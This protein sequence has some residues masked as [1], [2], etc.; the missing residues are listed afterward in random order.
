MLKNYFIVAYRNLIHNKLYSLIS[1]AGLAIGIACCLIIFLFVGHEFSYDNFH[2]NG[3]RL[4]RVIRGE[5]NQGELAGGGSGTC[6]LLRGELKNKYPE[7]TGVTR[8]L[9][10][11]TSVSH[12]NES[13]FEDVVFVDPDFFTMFSFN[14][15]EGDKNSVLNDP[16]SV[17]LTEEMARKY[18]DNADPVGKSVKIQLN[19]EFK[20]FTVSGVIEKPP[21]NSS[22]RFDFLLSQEKLNLIFPERQL[23]TWFLIFLT[24][25]VQLAPGADIASLQ[26][27]IGDN[28]NKLYFVDT[29]ESLYYNF[30]PITELHTDPRY[31]GESV[32]STNPLYSYILAGIA[33][34]ILLIACI[35]FV[36]LSIGRTSSRVR[37]VGLRKVVGAFR[38]QVMGQYWCESLVLCLFA[39]M[40]SILI[41]ELLLPIFNAIAQKELTFNI[42][43]EWSVLPALAAIVLITSFLAGFYPAVY[44]SK[45]LPVETLR[46][47][48]KIGSK[49]ILIRT[50]V[51]L[52]FTISIFL[53]F[54]T[55]VISSQVK[56]VSNARLGYDKDY[57]V[58]V[59]TGTTGEDAARLVERYRSELAGQSAIVDVT[60]YAYPVGGSW[61][62]LNLSNED[63]NTVLIGEDITGPSYAQSA[64]DTSLYFYMNWVDPHYIP[65]MKLNLVAGR[66]FMD[67]HEADLNGA[68][69]INETFAKKLGYD[70]PIG[71]KLPRGF[72]DATIVGVVEDF[73]YYPLHR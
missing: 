24:T 18:F 44:L 10:T 42:F 33:A 41:V 32:P 52:Q 5:K 36:T 4:Y 3:D 38:G 55:F 63:G 25:Y 40:L 57:V 6:Y 13:F 53:I 34:A 27:K 71:Q 26:Q 45:F 11:N 19:E 8:V 58:T 35:N 68:I 30:Q 20:D 46:R 54:S 2:A 22:F 72:S 39:L 67:N 69:I 21:V 43:S 49:N 14:L 29:D 1:I 62:Y 70:N 7:I 23:T 50:L 73:H 28:I 65:T 56:Y 51:I 47:Q 9:G 66:N 17:V 15:L 16:G 64:E 31:E 37:E 61:L 12:G 60:G 48:V 59:R